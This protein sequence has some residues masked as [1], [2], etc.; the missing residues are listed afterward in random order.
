MQRCK[1][2]RDARNAA[3][4]AIQLRRI[5]NAINP[6]DSAVEVAQHRLDALDTGHAWATGSPIDRHQLHHIMTLDPAQPS[7]TYALPLDLVGLVRERANDHN[8]ELPDTHHHRQLDIG[9][10]L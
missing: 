7:G 3:D 5:D 10:Q 6:P 1:V 4:S 2:A 9:L 8:I